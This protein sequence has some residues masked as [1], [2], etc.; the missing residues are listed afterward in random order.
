MTTPRN[1]R[2]QS[3]VPAALDTA[4]TAATPANRDPPDQANDAERKARVNND[5]LD[6]LK[7]PQQLRTTPSIQGVGLY[8]HATTPESLGLADAQRSSNPRFVP[9]GGPERVRKVKSVPAAPISDDVLKVFKEVQQAV[10]E[11]EQHASIRESRLN[12]EQLK[13]R[14]GGLNA[15]QENT[16][17]ISDLDEQQRLR[18]QAIEQQL[19]R[20]SNRAGPS[21]DV[22][23]SG[24]EENT[25][26]A[27]VAHIDPSMYLCKN[28]QTGSRTNLYDAGRDP[29]K[30]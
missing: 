12:A 10:N 6:L 18:V 26:A 19:G 24:I 13:V 22:V 8:T 4:S 1:R 3:D 16:A 5:L 30:R 14:Y 23:M 20:V 2:G 17:T 15:P 11:E 21:A 27:A 7:Q 9:I 25:G 29:R 28:A